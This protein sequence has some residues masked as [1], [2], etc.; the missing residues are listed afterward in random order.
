MRVFEMSSDAQESKYISNESLNWMDESAHYVL[1]LYV[2]LRYVLHASSSWAQVKSKQ[3]NFLIGFPKPHFLHLELRIT[4]LLLAQR[5]TL[6]QL[7][8]GGFVFWPGKFTSLE[9]QHY[10]E[11]SEDLRC[12][13]Y[14]NEL[15]STNSN[16]R[17]I[18]FP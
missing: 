4:D 14:T 18:H 7:H 10:H 12:V 13:L 2:M 6:F 17:S 15:I 1:M 8:E 16:T 11:S 5:L 3:M 9:K